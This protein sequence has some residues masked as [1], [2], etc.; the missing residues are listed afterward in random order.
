MVDPENPPQ[1]RRARRWI[2]RRK[3]HPAATGSRRATPPRR[4]ESGRPRA[5][6]RRRTT[7]SRCR[8]HQ[9]NWQGHLGQFR[10]ERQ[11]PGG[12]G[13][14]A[15]PARFARHRTVHRPAR[16]P[17]ADAG[18][19]AAIRRSYLSMLWISLTTHFTSDH[20]WLQIDGDT[21]TIGITDFAQSQLGAVVFVELPKAGRSLKKAETAAPVERVTAASD[22]YAPVSGEVIESNDALAADPSLINSDPQGK[23]WVFKLKLADK[24][25]LDGLMNEAAYKAHT[26]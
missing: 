17:R 9:Q 4:F 2:S 5:G 13:I 15:D 22:V 10:P 8:L 18:R 6:A 23:A 3:Y 24:S 7:V 11:R 19:Q 16:N 14:R 26:E 25:E 12:D 21:A 20:E 1:G